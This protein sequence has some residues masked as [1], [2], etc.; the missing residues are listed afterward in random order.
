MT[1]TS[2][3]QAEFDQIPFDDDRMAAFEGRLVH[4][5]NE[6]AVLMMTSIGHR[7]G[8]FDTLKGA[9]PLTSRAIAD[10][11]GLNE[12]YVREWLGNMV[13]GGVIELDPTAG[14]YR[15]PDE[16][17]ALLTRDGPAN[18]AV[19]AQ[20][21]PLLGTVEDEI[22]GCFRQGGG[23][24]YDRYPRF[25]EVMAEDSSQTVVAALDEHIL[26]LAAG[27]PERLSAGI[28]VLDVG[29]G[30]GLALMRMA[31]SYP[32]SRFTGYDLSAEATDWATAKARALGLDNVTFTARDLSD[33]HHTAP[34]AAFDLVTSFDA[35]HDQ[36]QPLN[37]LKG[38][39]RAVAEDGI[40]LAQD[41][42]GSSHHHGDRDHPLGPLLYAISCM[43]CMSVSL[44]QGGEG[45]GAMWG[46]ETAER[47]FR[48]A[49][50]STVDVHELDH[51]IQNYYYLCR[52]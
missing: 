32:K 13:T 27:L 16:H 30:R 35:I 24:S 25:H 51:D 33:F 50:F 21:V 44:A 10:R 42:K 36:A 2:P 52:P 31:E 29:C 7:T 3:I 22:I 43:H 17:A 4:A 49:G 48:D 47:Y 26:P 6:S 11:A 14:T 37:V 18:L 46:R 8:L 23:L 34:A 9:P 5:L 38:I 1:A 12:R 40:Y 28:K 41:I 15:L 39:R 45:L 19:F 20:Y